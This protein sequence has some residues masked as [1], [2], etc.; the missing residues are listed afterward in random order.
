LLKC[1]YRISTPKP[2]IRIITAHPYTFSP[3]TLGDYLRKT[4]IDLGLTQ[5][6]VAKD[7]LKTSV[8]NVRNWEANR[9]EISLS[10]RPKV[11]EFIS[12]C[13]YDVSIPFGLKFKQRRENFGLSVKKLAILL[14][15]H[16]STID[17]WERCKH[18]PSQ[19]SLKIIEGFLKSVSIEKRFKHQIYVYLK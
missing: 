11:I 16:R 17:N 1:Q 15:V 8:D 19:K 14:K 9:Y 4:R 12:Y 18:Q 13:P 2:P 10:F 5:K 6:K 7:I 3:I